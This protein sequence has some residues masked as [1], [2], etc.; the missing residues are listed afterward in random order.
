MKEEGSVTGGSDKRKKSKKMQDSKSED[1]DLD[2]PL[3]FLSR[4]EQDHSGNHEECK[5]PT[6][7][8]DPLGG[9]DL[10]A[11]LVTMTSSITASELSKMS[12]KDIRR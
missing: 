3:A 7:V 11:E 8:E 9:I 6:N 10:H 4:K 12:V 1:P 5:T 2:T